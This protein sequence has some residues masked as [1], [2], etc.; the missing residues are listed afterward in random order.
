MS[1]L[2]QNS[3]MS[4]LRNKFSKIFEKLFTIMQFSKMKIIYDQTKNKKLNLQT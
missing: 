1:A 2:D 3:N 4:F